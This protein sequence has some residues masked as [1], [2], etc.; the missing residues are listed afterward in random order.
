MLT[1]NLRNKMQ[2]NLQVKHS[3][4]E[5]KLT[6]LSDA[7][8]LLERHF[9]QLK[10]S[11]DVQNLQCQ[12]VFNLMNKLALYNERRA[13]LKRMLRKTDLLNKISGQDN[14]E[15]FNY[16]VHDIENNFLYQIAKEDLMKSDFEN[17]KVSFQ[18][19]NG[20]IQYKI[21]YYNNHI[22]NLN[23]AYKDDVEDDV[24]VDIDLNN[25]E[26]YY[27]KLYLKNTKP[28]AKFKKIFIDD[29]NFKDIQSANDSTNNLT[30]NVLK[31]LKKKIV[32][33]RNKNYS[34][35]RLALGNEDSKISSNLD[36]LQ[37]YRSLHNDQ[38]Q[39]EFSVANN[40]N[41]D[42]INIEVSIANNINNDQIKKEVSIESNINDKDELSQLVT[43]DNKGTSY[44]GI[45]SE[46]IQ[47]YTQFIK[48]N[49]IHKVV[50]PPEK[51]RK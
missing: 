27:F 11:N 31:K 1:M 36:E 32:F 3:I 22:L 5:V 40:I 45:T 23:I 46:S 26:N 44:V 43:K 10:S 39:S 19:M 16:H 38:M 14:W 2:S 18:T 51:L 6:N 21:R 28:G 7:V 35:T 25:Q 24:V 12:R 4:K 33:V 50:D 29:F 15:E 8:L 34:L 42:P 20:L 17:L 47:Y 48:K 13:K 30:K 41:D 9:F 49:K 37:D